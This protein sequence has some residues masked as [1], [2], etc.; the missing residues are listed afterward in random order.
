MADV[1]P[2]DS[3][4]GLLVRCMW[5]ATRAVVKISQ[6]L[7]YF[8]MAIPGLD[9]HGLVQEVY[10]NLALSGY[11]GERIGPFAWARLEH[12]QTLAVRDEMKFFSLKI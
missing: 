1:H 7:V 6:Y 10:Q 12:G 11:R 9:T 8:R 2:D 3:S 5:R 4:E